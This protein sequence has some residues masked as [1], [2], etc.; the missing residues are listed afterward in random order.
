MLVD[1]SYLSLSSVTVVE[2]TSDEP[3]VRAALVCGAAGCVLGA[4]KV[5]S[6]SSTGAAGC[7]ADIRVIIMPTPSMIASNTPPTIADRAAY[8]PCTCQLLD[9]RGRAHTCLAR[10]QIE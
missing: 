8:S 2:L 4:G 7:G 9:T 3:L 5:G 6:S 1:A 10:L